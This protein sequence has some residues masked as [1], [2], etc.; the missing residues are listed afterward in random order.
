MTTTV[1][2]LSATEETESIRFEF[3]LAHPPEKV[4]RALTEEN[5]VSEGLLPARGLRLEPGAA[6]TLAAPAQEGRV[7]TVQC[8]PLEI[9]EHRRP[10]Y[11]WWG[12]DC[13]VSVLAFTLA[14][15]D[16]RARLP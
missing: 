12:A 3:D 4:W 7:G 10:S 16:T 6:F 13:L 14:W 8:R 9:D 11:S 1:R 15:T 2:D 5:L